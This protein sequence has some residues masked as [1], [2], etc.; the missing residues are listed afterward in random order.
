MAHEQQD[1]C[2]DFQHFYARKKQQL[3]VEYEANEFLYAHEGPWPQMSFDYPYGQAPEILSI[4]K[5]E[6]EDWARTIG[7]YYAD[8]AIGTASDPTPFGVAGAE[9]AKD[10]FFQSGLSGYADL[11]DD[12][13]LELIC[14][15]LY[16][17]FLCPLDP[18]DEELFDLGNIL[19]DHSDEWEY[20]KS[21]YRCMM[22]NWLQ[23][24]ARLSKRSRV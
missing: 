4:P 23:Q 15:G 19:S 11:S 1:E 22:V 7:K 2:R 16:S 18:Q 21:D 14:E 5:P 8:N 13:F 6:M 3:G 17:K 9:F 12:E 20:F 24:T 10:N